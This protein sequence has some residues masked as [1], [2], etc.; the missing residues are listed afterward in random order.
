M[1]VEDAYARVLAELSQLE[2]WQRRADR[3]PPAPS[4]GAALRGASVAV[5]AEVKRRSPS[6][7]SIN[8]NIDAQLRARSY[9][10]AGAAAVSVLTEPDWFAG[11]AQDLSDVAAAVDV[12]VIRKDFIVA[13][14]QLYEARGRGAAAALLIA[15]ALS[16]G[17]L[18]QLH[19]IGTY[20]GL[21]LL[22]D[23]VEIFLR[24]HDHAVTVTDHHIP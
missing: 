3:M 5:I 23:V 11:S 6:K 18:A 20:I 10:E 13:P 2:E 17:A 9:V 22:V 12:P 7:G 15:R 1:L 8:A 14:I 16:P 19:D 4:F 24:H 21:E